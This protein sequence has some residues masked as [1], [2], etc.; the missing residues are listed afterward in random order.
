MESVR[1]LRAVGKYLGDGAGI[2]TRPISGHDF[3][4][5]MF[6][7]PFCQFASIPALEQSQKMMV[8]RVIDDCVVSLALFEAHIIHP[9][10]VDVRLVFDLDMG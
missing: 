3:Y 9:D 6:F 8:V 2:G 7:E 5:W 1:Y 10:R 4:L